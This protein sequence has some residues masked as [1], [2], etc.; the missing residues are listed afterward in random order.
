[1]SSRSSWSNSR[2]SR[3]AEVPGS[4]IVM[5]ITANLRKSAF[6]SLPQVYVK[7][8]SALVD[9]IQD[10][11]TRLPITSQELFSILDDASEGTFLCA[12][13]AESLQKYVFDG[14]AGKIGLEMKNL[15]ACTSF[16]VEQKLVKACLVDKDAEALRCQKL[17]FEEEEAAQKRQAELLE[18]KR[19]RKLRQKEQRIR[20]QL[21]VDAYP[22]STEAS[23]PQSSIEV[24][25]STPD[26]NLS[27]PVE[28][29]KLS[30][31]E[32]N[33][34]IEAQGGS[35][36]DHSDYA[37]RQKPE[38]QMV[39]KNGFK[40]YVARWQP[41]NSVKSRR[42]NYHVDHSLKRVHAHKQREQRG[43]GGSKV[44]TK[45]PKSENGGGGIERLRV[46]ND[47]INQTDQNNG[48]LMIGSISVTLR[49]SLGEPHKVNSLVV[50]QENGDTCQLAETTSREVLATMSNHDSCELNVN[51]ENANNS[52]SQMEDKEKQERVPISVHDAKAFLAQ[53]WKEA[54]SGE[55]V[56][57]LLSSCEP[58]I[59]PDAHNNHYPSERV[60]LGNAENRLVNTGVVISHT[61]GNGNGNVKPQFRTKPEKGMK[62]K[63]IPKQRPTN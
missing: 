28:P 10:R 41:S 48:Q 51:D 56:M 8:G 37:I 36:S 7:A 25:S 12:G 34:D 52:C 22:A 50:I 33:I 9:I 42:N 1:M 57:L 49:N 5:N 53:R 60:I 44:W 59:R 17:L 58:P 4:S 46:H 6:L 16:L 21:K 19:Q 29:T 26:E 18:R 62:I 47:A 61:H 63:Y 40:H 2:K 11:P 24:D 23:S 3:K 27:L 13:T 54:A 43:V 35:T 55:H 30:N 20:D 32:N 15:I 31:S 38:Y 39:H 14:E 45:K